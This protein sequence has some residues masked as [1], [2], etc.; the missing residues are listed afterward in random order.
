MNEQILAELQKTNRM[1]NAILSISVD[2]HI[3]EADLAKPRPRSIDRMLYDN[4]MTGVEIAKLLGKSKQAVSQALAS[5]GKVK[6]SKPMASVETKA[7]EV[8]SEEDA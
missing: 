2:R 6:K 1:L 4:G 7:T 3:R 8:N 5:D